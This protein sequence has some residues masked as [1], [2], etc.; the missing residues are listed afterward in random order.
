MRGA[1]ETALDFL[2]TRSIAGRVGQTLPQGSTPASSLKALDDELRRLQVL[3]FGTALR[4]VRWMPEG[5][6]DMDGRVTGDLIRVYAKNLGE[7]VRCVRHEVLHY[8]VA[9]CQFPYVE[10]V[11]GFI[12]RV[13]KEAYRRTEKLVENLAGLEW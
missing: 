12:S 3:G 7:A 1:Y 6:G 10:L 5:E 13:S 8:E 11:N 4:G 2:E 9:Q